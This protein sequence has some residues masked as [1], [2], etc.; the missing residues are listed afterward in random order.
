MELPGRRKRGKL[1][2][3]LVDIVKEELQRVGVTEV[4]ARE[5]KTNDPL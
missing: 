1:E 5:M 3:R 4:D 2:R